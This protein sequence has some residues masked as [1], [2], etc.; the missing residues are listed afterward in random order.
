MKSKSYSATYDERQLL[1]GRRT[2][3]KDIELN[4]G[5]LTVESASVDYSAEL[6]SPHGKLDEVR[7]RHLQKISTQPK[8]YRERLISDL[9]GKHRIDPEL[10]E[11]LA[12]EWGL[13]DAGNS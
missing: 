3:E 6:G 2:I 7:R 9:V 12:D 11:E 8:G 13:R 5:C 4:Y 10:Q 1:F